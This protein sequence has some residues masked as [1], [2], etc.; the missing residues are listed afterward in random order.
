MNASAASWNSSY[1]GDVLDRAAAGS[2]VEP[3]FDLGAQL[4]DPGVARQRDRAAPDELGAGVALGVVRGGAHQAAVEVA[5]ADEVIQHLGP[6]LAGVEHGRALGAHALAVSARE[7][8]GG[9]SHVPAEPEAQRRCR[10]ALELADH[11]RERPADQLGR[12]SVDV[13]A[14]QPADVVGLED[15]GARRRCASRRMLPTG[16][17]GNNACAVHADMPPVVILCGGRGTRLQERGSSLPKP[18]VEIGGRPILW[19][20]INIHLS[21]GFRRCLLLTGYRGEEIEAFVAG[22]RWPDDAE[23]RC[24]DTGVDTPTGGR[25]HRAAAVA[26]RRSG[27]AWPT[28]T[29]SPTSTSERFS[30]STAAHGAGV[31]MAVVQPRLPFG[32]ARLD[33]DGSVLGFTEKPRSEEWV[34][35]GFFCFERSALGVLEPDSVLEREPL[36]RLAAAGRAARVPPRGVLGVHGH[37][38]GRDH[39]Q[40][41]VGRGPAPWKL[42]E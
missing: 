36:E 25:L 42:W 38:Q 41:P 3:G 37:L 39:A 40:R 8:R 34:N 11:P 13:A 5:R 27:S 9:Q 10:L 28:P 35:A 33:G 29:A 31:T 17:S 2:A 12:G 24:L 1:S 18:L 23:I 20:V 6:D 26:R 32:V 19:H 21:Q 14:V 4:A 15:P 22:E 16:G 30:R 7:L